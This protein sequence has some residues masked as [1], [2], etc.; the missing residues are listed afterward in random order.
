[1]IEDIEAALD[2]ARYK[3]EVY[4]SEWEKLL[5]KSGNSRSD[6]ASAVGVWAG[7]GTG[8][9]PT[10]KSRNMGNAVTGIFSKHKGTVQENLER[11][12]KEAEVKVKLPKILA[13]VMSLIEEV[14]ECLKWSLGKYAYAYECAVLAD[15]LTL[16]PSNGDPGMMEMIEDIDSKTDLDNFLRFTA[17]QS[18]RVDRTSIPYKEYEMSPIARTYANPKTIFGVPLATQVERD[19]HAIPLII[20]KCTKASGQSS[21]VARLR[22]EFNLDADNVDLQPSANAADINNITSV[23]KMY[24]R[25]LPGGLIPHP[26]RDTLLGMFPTQENMV[27]VV[28]C[29]MRALPRMNVEILNYLV[30]HLDKVQAFQEFNM[31][32][33]ENLG[34][35]FGPTIIPSGDDPVNAAMDIRRSAKVVKFM[36]DNRRAIFEL[37]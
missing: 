35:V 31:M 37:L 8:S 9:A 13:S 33:S 17:H 10:S 11:M 36:L 30:A 16:K 23:L 4:S 5:I 14:D 32:N 20:V 18:G 26:H 2:K 19:G 27:N 12:G 29:T 22:N 28:V 3:Y 25:E 34:I 6:G 7:P 24:L 21:Q 1:P 15:A